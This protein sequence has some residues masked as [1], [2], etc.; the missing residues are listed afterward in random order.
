MSTAHHKLS[1]PV[2]EGLPW[3]Y[4]LGG[5]AAVLASYF[6]TSEALSMVLGLPGLLAVLAGVVVLLRRRGYRRLRAQYDAPHALD[7]ATAGMA[8][9]PE[10]SPSHQDAA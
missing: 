6:Q 7:E 2:Y 10:D 8:S 9:G 5:M 1:R 3:V 4:L